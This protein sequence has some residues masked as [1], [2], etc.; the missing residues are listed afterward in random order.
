MARV[1]YEHGHNG[2]FINAEDTI[3]A[4]DPDHGVKLVL[5]NSSKGVYNPI[6]QEVHTDDAMRAKAAAYAR[7][8][9]G[10]GY[11]SDFAFKG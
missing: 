7:T 2:I 6:M 9:V 4:L 8:R 3:Q 11:N 10:S 5:G 1:Q